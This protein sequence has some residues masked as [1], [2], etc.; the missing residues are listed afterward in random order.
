M[1][2]VST[3]YESTLTS[4]S[5]DSWPDYAP[6]M[7]LPGL[8]QGGTEDDEVIGCPTPEHHYAGLAGYPGVAFPFDLLVTLYGDAQPAPWGVRELRFGFPDG[9]LSSFAIEHALDLAHQAHRAWRRGQRVLI[10]CQAGVNRSGLVSALVLMFDG[11]T[12]ADAIELLRCQR[13]QVVLSN[14][15]FEAWLRTDAPAALAS[16]DPSSSRPF[17]ASA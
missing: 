6:D 10:R 3:G 16:F 5:E 17:P 1:S 8:F 2:N 7:I 9:P 11:Y 12:A 14:A 15:H 4:W 13:G